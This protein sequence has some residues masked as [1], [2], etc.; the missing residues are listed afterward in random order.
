MKHMLGTWLCCAIAAIL[1][2]VLMIVVGICNNE[3][4]ISIIAIIGS[5]IF[6]TYDLVK[7][8]YD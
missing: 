6:Q 8:Y 2:Y 5:A 4:L 7:H 3:V 1:C